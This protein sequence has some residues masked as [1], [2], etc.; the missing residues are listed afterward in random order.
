[1]YTMFRRRESL[2]L[3]VQQRRCSLVL[4][5]RLVTL[6]PITPTPR[7]DDILELWEIYTIVE[8]QEDPP[9][10]G[11]LSACS[12]RS[13]DVD[14]LADE[15]IHPIGALQ[16][17]GFRHIVGTLWNVSEEYC[18]HVARVL[19]ET[20]RDEGLTDTSISRGGDFIEPSNKYGTNK[21]R[22]SAHGFSLGSICSF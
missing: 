2:E 19:Y 11:Y 14:D 13:N 10:L 4:S 20:L 17:A 21:S 7:K 15:S 12:T 5:F 16:L 22:G 6:T 18:V 1:M 8:F 3:L 9:F